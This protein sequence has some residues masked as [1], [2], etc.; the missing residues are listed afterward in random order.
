MQT[1]MAFKLLDSKAVSLCSDLL[2]LGDLGS[3]FGLQYIWNIE[4]TVVLYHTNNF[5]TG[6]VVD[7][8]LGITELFKRQ[9]RRLCPMAFF[10]EKWLLADDVVDD[11]LRF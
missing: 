2:L 9:K 4:L 3:R 6:D 1:L 11:F 8:V 10:A 7:P 5:G